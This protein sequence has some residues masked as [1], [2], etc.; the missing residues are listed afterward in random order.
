MKR[1]L[2]IAAVVAVFGIGIGPTFAAMDPPKIPP[3]GVEGPDIRQNTRPPF[4]GVEGPNV[5]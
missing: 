1:L 5:R 2:A 3:K 4:Q